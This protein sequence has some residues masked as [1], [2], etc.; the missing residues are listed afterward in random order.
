VGVAVC[1]KLLAQKTSLPLQ[2]E[3]FIAGL[4]HDMGIVIIDHYFPEK[5]EAI[6]ETM[7][8]ERLSLI[9]AELKVLGFTHALVGKLVAERWNFPGLL[10]E[11]I[12]YHNK[13]FQNE[14]Y[15]A[16]IALIYAADGLC[17]EAG[18]GTDREQTNY[19][20]EVKVW[21]WLGLKLAER[22]NILQELKTG[23]KKAAEFMN[24]ISMDPETKD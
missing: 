1:A 14:N 20:L 5:F 24:L 13:P 4:L 21:S 15:C 2:E 3:A 19:N 17:R 16:T 12:R 6:L 11:T 22:Q 7:T 9:Q 23:I 10:V 8:K 18:E